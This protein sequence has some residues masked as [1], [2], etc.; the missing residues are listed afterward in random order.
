[1]RT[2][3]RSIRLLAALL[4]AGSATMAAASEGNIFKGP[5]GSRLDALAKIQPGLGTVM[6]EY[7]SRF[8]NV[9]FAAKGGNWG[10]AQYQLDE[11]R[12]IQEVGEATRPKNAPLLKSFEDAFLVPLE[13]AILAKKWPEFDGLYRDTMEGCN[14]CHAST[15]H[16]FIHFK[17]PARP[18]EDYIDFAVKSDPK[19]NR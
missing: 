5:A 1:M 10:L 7:G 19:G 4:A 16:S 12:E 18:V 15:A 14:G 2:I 13:K 6:I 3:W 8:T 11:M 17:L 9:Y